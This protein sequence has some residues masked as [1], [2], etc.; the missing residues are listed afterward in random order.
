[1][2]GSLIALA[3]GVILCI[4]VGRVLERVGR[5]FLD[6][7]FKDERVSAAVARLL[8]VMFY[9]LAFG[10]IALVGT[11]PMPDLGWLQATALK[12]GITLLVLGGAHAS[13]VG[14]LLIVKKRRR[15]Q[16]LEEEMA[17]RVRAGGS[18]RHR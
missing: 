9:L 14:L 5:P 7:V 18:P 15:R 17:R 13:V 2:I 1:M 6:D 12:L 10:S 11:L 8:S 16:I 3:L 4:V